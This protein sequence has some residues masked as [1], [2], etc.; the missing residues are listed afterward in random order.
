VLAAYR[1]GDRGR[2]ADDDAVTSRGERGAEASLLRRPRVAMEEHGETH[3]RAV[4]RTDPL[5]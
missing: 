4:Y 1:G 2:I 5:E 3:G